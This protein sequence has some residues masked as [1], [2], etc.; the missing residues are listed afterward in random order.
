M[1]RITF[2]PL[3]LRIFKK[4]SPLEKDRITY[5]SVSLLLAKIRPNRTKRFFKKICNKNKRNPCFDKKK[6]SPSIDNINIPLSWKF[7][8]PNFQPA[9]S[10]RIYQP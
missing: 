5:I 7:S 6:K 3:L 8:S 2:N 9:A 1:R 4:I 10:N